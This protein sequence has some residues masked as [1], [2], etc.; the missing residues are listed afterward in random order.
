MTVFG[1][2]ICDIGLIDGVTGNSVIFSLIGI[3]GVVTGGVIGNSS[4]FLLVGNSVIF[5]LIGITGVVIGG[6]I[7]LSIGLL[8]LEVVVFKD[9]ITGGNVSFVKS[10]CGFSST[11]IGGSFVKSG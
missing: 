3:T 2:S 11:G 9:D 8:I 5:S 10:G 7:S 4:I 6:V 1:C